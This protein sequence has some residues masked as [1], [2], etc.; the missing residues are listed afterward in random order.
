LTVKVVYSPVKVE[1]VKFSLS[2][3][4]NWT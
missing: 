4:S 3:N 1:K 2:F